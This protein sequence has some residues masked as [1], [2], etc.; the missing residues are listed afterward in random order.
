MYNQA[1]AVKNENPDTGR[2][3]QYLQGLKQSI[4]N[5]NTNKQQDWIYENEDESEN[6]ERVVERA[7]QN[8][9][10]RTR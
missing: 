9:L 5:I 10:G 6:N 7:P 3:T 2:T 8:R 1:P 4:A